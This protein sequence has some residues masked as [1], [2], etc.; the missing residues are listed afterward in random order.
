ML[1]L[2]GRVLFHPLPSSSNRSSAQL[3]QRCPHV[4]ARQGYTLTQI[5]VDACS[6]RSFTQGCLRQLSLTLERLGRTGQ[7]ARMSDIQIV[8]VLICIAYAQK[9]P[10]LPSL[11]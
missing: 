2:R 1:N 6:A 10:I 7:V 5:F 11:R 3:T 9:S 4:A 8:E